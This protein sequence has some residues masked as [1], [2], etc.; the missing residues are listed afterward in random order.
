M[1][2]LRYE[3]LA[4]RFLTA[5]VTQADELGV[6]G[7]DGAVVA[8]FCWASAI[9]CVW[10]GKGKGRG[11]ALPVAVPARP[12]VHAKVVGGVRSGRCRV[13]GDDDPAD[14]AAGRH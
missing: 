1:T 10:L 6:S 12:R 5:R 13:A 2:V 4:R 11:A 3:T 8:R 14:D 7:L 9:A